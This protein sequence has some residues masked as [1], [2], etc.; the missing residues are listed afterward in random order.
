M[1]KKKKIIV[2]CIV[3]G[4]VTD[5]REKA[6]EIAKKI[7]EK[8]SFRRPF[9]DHVDIECVENVE[10]L[11]T[12]HDWSYWS[13]GK[14]V[15]GEFIGEKPSKSISP[16]S[17]VAIDLIEDILYSDGGYVEGGVE[18][19][20]SIAEILEKKKAVSLTGKNVGRW[21]VPNEFREMRVKHQD[22][23]EEILYILDE[24]GTDAVVFEIFHD[25]KTLEETLKKYGVQRP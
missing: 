11:Y 10:P 19:L 12:E 17:S 7:I 22:G 15:Q 24:I 13:D 6:E 2:R 16:L 3:E 25:T 5:S 14:I 4:W 9:R 23:R 18:S 21:A 1:P 20:T 8:E